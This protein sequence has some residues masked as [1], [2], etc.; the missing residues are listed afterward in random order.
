MELLSE[1]RNHVQV[2][3]Y[4]ITRERGQANQQEMPRANNKSNN[5]SPVS[6]KK[7]TKYKTLIIQSSINNSQEVSKTIPNVGNAE[8]F[9]K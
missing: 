6:Y 4:A 3:N 7:T 2:L 1:V 9:G 5:W 8:K